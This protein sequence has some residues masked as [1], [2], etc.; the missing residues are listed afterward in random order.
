MDDLGAR[1]VI[2]VDPVS[3]AHQAERI[4]LVLGL[5]DV[6]VDVLHRLDGLEHVEHGLVGTAVSGTPQGCGTGRD[7]GKGI[8]TRAACQ[9]Y[10]RGRCILFVIRVQNEQDVQRLLRQRI[11]HIVL[12]GCGEHHVQQIAGVAETVAWIH[13]RFADVVLVAGSGDGRRLGD[14]AMSADLAVMRI[15]HIHRIMIEGGQG[16]DHS[17]HHRHRMRIVVEALEETQQR[18]IDHR[19]MNDNVA[20]VLQLLRRRQFAVVQQ[21]GH[22]QEV[23]LFRQLLD[24]VAPVAQ[25]ALVAVYIGDRAVATRRGHEARIECKHLA[26]TVQR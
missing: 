23:G 7:A 11:H 4:V 21:I 19:V 14:Q 26:L 1:I 22:L 17:H 8:G 6:P 10:G 25:N 13:H 5:G 2:L 15:H 24:R 20:E 9:A 3:K 18:I 12:T 16:A